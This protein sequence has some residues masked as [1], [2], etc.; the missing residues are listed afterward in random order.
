VV[1]NIIN[2]IYP[3]KNRNSFLHI[4]LNF[5][6]ILNRPIKRKVFFYIFFSRS[7][8]DS[9]SDSDCVFQPLV[10]LLSPPPSAY[11]NQA[12]QPFFAS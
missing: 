9:I 7:N 3:V 5:T 12:E 6:L 8:S 11:Q 10:A 4:F 2:L 1:S